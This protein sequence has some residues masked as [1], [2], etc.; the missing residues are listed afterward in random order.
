MGWRLSIDKLPTRVNDIPS[1]LCP[2]CGECTESVSHLFF[3]RSF[4]TQVYNRFERWWD[5][6]IPVTRCYQQWLDWFLA[7]RLNKVQKQFLKATFLSLWWHVWCHRNACVFGKIGGEVK[8]G[9]YSTKVFDFEHH[10][11]T[12]DTGIICKSEVGRHE[13][14]PYPHATN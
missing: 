12:Y 3:E 2:I 10:A 5:L 6:H 11:S 14:Y 7:L 8:T 4:V 13:H 9:E 1:V